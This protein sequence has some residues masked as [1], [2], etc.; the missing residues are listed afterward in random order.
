MISKKELIIGLRWDRVPEEIIKLIN[1]LQKETNATQLE[2][3]LE[4]WI[5]VNNSMLETHRNFPNRGLQK[6]MN[7]MTLEMNKALN[8][9]SNP[10]KEQMRK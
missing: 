3:L 2:V 10:S 5:F 1:L 8:G 6:T 7:Q 9:I 4:I